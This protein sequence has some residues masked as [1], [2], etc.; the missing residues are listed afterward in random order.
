MSF[1]R[2]PLNPTPDDPGQ[3]IMVHPRQIPVGLDVDCLQG[4]LYWSDLAFKAIRRA[5]Y[6]GS[7][8]ELVIEGPLVGSPEG[9]AVDWIS[10][11]V[12]WIDSQG[13]TIKVTRLDGRLGPKT[14]VSEGLTDPRGIVVHPG[15]GKMYFSD[16]NRGAPKIEVRFVCFVNSCSCKHAISLFRLMITFSLFKLF[17]NI[18]SS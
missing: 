8:S 10:R 3:L 6:N 13:D 12:Y 15:Y 18:F 17:C 5:P 1:L 9:I 11:N 16:W 2:L 14:L 7:R 4:S